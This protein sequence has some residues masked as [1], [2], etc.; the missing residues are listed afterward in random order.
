[1]ETEKFNKKLL[2]IDIV[3][4]KDWHHDEQFVEC[5]P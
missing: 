1:M 2:K 4:I 5:Y 3:L